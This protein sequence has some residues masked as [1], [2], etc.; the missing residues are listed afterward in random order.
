[1]FAEEPQQCDLL[2]LLLSSHLIV[3][4]LPHCEV[5]KRSQSSDKRNEMC[6]IHHFMSSKCGT[7]GQAHHR[8]SMHSFEARPV[9]EE[10]QISAALGCRAWSNQGQRKSPTS[11]CCGDALGPLKVC[12]DCDVCLSTD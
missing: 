4:H 5:E 3:F 10:T 1:M 11:K 2:L 6:L 7:K 8:F 9:V 12:H